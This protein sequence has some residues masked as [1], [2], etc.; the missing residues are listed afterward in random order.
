M[1]DFLIQGDG[2][3]MKMWIAGLSIDFG[4]VPQVRQERKTKGGFATMNDFD[5]GWARHSRQ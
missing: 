2:D 1:L 5:S 3:G 4:L